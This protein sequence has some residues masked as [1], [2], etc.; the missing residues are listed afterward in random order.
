MAGRLF[1]LR[2]GREIDETALAA[3]IGRATYLLLG[4][5]HDNADH[6]RLQ[7]R[8]LRR[9]A[10]LSAGRLAVV[11]EMLTPEQLPALGAHRRRLSRDVGGL[12]W[13]LGWDSSGWPDW[14]IYEP[15]FAAAVAHQL[16]MHAG[17]IPRAEVRKISRGGYAAL[18]DPALSKF[19]E[20]NPP[21]EPIRKA[22]SDTIIASHCGHASAAI[23]PA[24][25]AIQ[26]AR[27]ATMAKGLIAAARGTGTAVLI[28]G[29]GHTRQDRGVPQFL[30]AMG[31]SGTV[32]NIA[33]VEVRPGRDRPAAYAE[34]YDAAALPFD[35]AWFTPAVDFADPCEKFRRALEKMNRPT[36]PTPTG[37][38]HSPG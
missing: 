1:D 16:P 22:M 17:N 14:Q 23:V 8:I 30:D 38:N 24:M 28:A 29:T 5:K 27:D 7:A 12:R 36:N 26:R 2:N 4:E 31:A 32:L 6:H 11:L 35:Y 33:F 3:Q 18:S 25:I 20:E 21:S 15:I 19:L 34:I 37:K 13:I 9:A 10:E